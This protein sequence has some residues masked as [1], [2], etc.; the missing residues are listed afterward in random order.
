MPAER[1]RGSRRTESDGE[2]RLEKH[3]QR[4]IS[5]F[6]ER[7]TGQRLVW[8]M[9]VEPVDASGV[10]FT[11]TITP[12]T[13]N[14]G[15]PPLVDAPPTEV[16]LFP[17]TEEGSPASRRPA[18]SKKKPENHIPRPP[19]AF[20]LFRS[21]FIKSQHVS[22]EVETNHSTLSKIIGLTWQNLPEQERQVWH[23]KAK[24]ALEEHKRKF[25]QY[26]FRP[27]QSKKGGTAE[28]R[29]VREVEPKDMKRCA[30]IAELLATGMK[31]QELESAMAE[32]DKHHVPE[33][34][35]RFEAPITARTYRRS[36]SAPIP[37]TENTK[38][39]QSF[40]TT[41]TSIKN[42]RASSIRPTR[43]PTPEVN[44]AASLDLQ[45]LKQEPSFDFNKFSFEK[46][47]S[48]SP[49]YTCDPLTDVVPSSPVDSAGP[50]LYHLQLN[51]ETPTILDDWNSCA[52]PITPNTPD[53]LSSP[54]PSP[55]FSD[56]F[57]NFYTPIEKRIPGDFSFPT[58]QHCGSELHL[59]GEPYLSSTTDYTNFHPHSDPSSIMDISAFL[60]ADLD[61]Y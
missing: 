51:I 56:H 46:T 2:I 25:P 9:P 43:Y 19:N 53:Y 60:S 34:V 33:V 1:T 57:A 36:S 26:A 22:T 55:S 42:G 31:G 14:D 52:T 32:F 29:R 50:D 35:T 49:A 39:Q 6:C 15:P 28:K 54:S 18:H 38:S 4:S 8:T 41:V 24:A 20:I 7:F 12:T 58:Y 45:S 40:F 21:S 61:T 30:K 11:T 27:T 48:P 5:S 16:I 10:S 17:P 13:F 23:A 44:Q 3:Q 37:D 59:S 47:G